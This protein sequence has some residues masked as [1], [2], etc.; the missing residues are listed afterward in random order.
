[1]DGFESEP[2]NLSNNDCIINRR[3]VLP[4]SYRRCSV[5]GG[6]GGSSSMDN[7]KGKQEAVDTESFGGEVQLNK[8]F[9]LKCP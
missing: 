6:K 1:M 7:I 2:C 3:F 9:L 5:G 4:R 8:T